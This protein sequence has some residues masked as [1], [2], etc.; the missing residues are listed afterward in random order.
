[1]PTHTKKRKIMERSRN[2]FLG[3]LD[4]PRT[5]QVGILSLRQTS[6]DSF[7]HTNPGLFV[8]IVW[9]LDFKLSY[10]ELCRTCPKEVRR[11]YVAA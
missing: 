2:Q 4:S 9:S 5:Q 10:P 11:I 8:A 7:P 3:T 6:L 1:M